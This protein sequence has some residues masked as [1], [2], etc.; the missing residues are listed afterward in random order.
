[1][2]FANVPLQDVYVSPSIVTSSQHL[3]QHYENDTSSLPHNNLAFDIPGEQSPSLGLEPTPECKI[4][5]KDVQ[6]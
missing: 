5:P 2:H 3:W 4:I 6:T 1:M